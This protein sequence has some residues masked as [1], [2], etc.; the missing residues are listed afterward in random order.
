MATYMLKDSP[1]SLTTC[2]TTC[3]T[4]DSY[5]K[6][7]QVG[8]RRSIRYPPLSYQKPHLKKIK[9]LH[10]YINFIINTIYN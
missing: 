2:S 8:S 1:I 5:S 3:E 9:H 6:V 7:F 10:C 4:K